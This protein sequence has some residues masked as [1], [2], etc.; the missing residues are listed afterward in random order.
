MSEV[1]PACI[2]F[3]HLK[4]YYRMIDLLQITD[5]L[6]Q[7][8]KFAADDSNQYGSLSFLQLL[9]IGGWIMVPL[10]IMLLLA[11]I[12]FSKL[13][14]YF[15]TGRLLEHIEE[16]GRSCFHFICGLIYLCI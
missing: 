5:T 16:I 8:T 14:S 4:K 1:V 11:G 12:F 6:N 9:K 13:H 2:T 3:T 7:I 10:V 15:L